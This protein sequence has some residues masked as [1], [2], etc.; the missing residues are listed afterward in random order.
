MTIGT[1]PRAA[2]SGVIAIVNCDGASGRLC[3]GCSGGS[4]AERRADQRRVLAAGLAERRTPSG[5]RPSS[6]TG[7]RAPPATSASGRAGTSRRPA[8]AATC[9]TSSRTMAPWSSSGTSQVASTVNAA[10]AIPHGA[11]LRPHVHARRRGS[12]PGSARRSPACRTTGGSRAAP[13]AGRP[14]PRSCRPRGRGAPPCGPTPPCSARAAPGRAARSGSG[15]ARSGRRPP[16]RLGTDLGAGVEPGSARGEQ[17]AN[18]GDEHAS[19][20]DAGEHGRISMGRAG[21]SRRAGHRAGIVADA[22]R[23]LL[24][25]DRRCSMA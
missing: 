15:R 5:P 10:C 19:A 16:A 21:A 3:A 25:L 17:A 18:H 23:C 7:R 24:T 22:R 13:S 1:R 9:V 2:V 4:I 6:C 11:G 12:R 8:A 14:T 20:Q